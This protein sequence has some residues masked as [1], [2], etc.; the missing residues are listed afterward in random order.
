M[1]PAS[2]GCRRDVVLGDRNTISTF[3][4]V[5]Q[6]CTIV[7]EQQDVP[8]LQ[9][10]RAVELV[11]PLRGEDTRHPGPAVGA[12]RHGNSCRIHHLEAPRLR[13]FPHQKRLQFL[14]CRRAGMQHGHTLLRHLDA[15]VGIAM[16]NHRPLRQGAAIVLSEPRCRCLLADTLQSAPAE[17]VSTQ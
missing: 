4:I 2:Q 8:S 10:H 11:E 1:I 13:R 9:L 17:T 12:V 14:A 7:N 3:D 6:R 16:H 5:K 15:C